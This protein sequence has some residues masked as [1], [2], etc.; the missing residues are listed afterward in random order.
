MELRNSLMALYKHLG[1]LAPAADKLDNK[2]FADI[3]AGAR[4]RIEQLAEHP[5]ADKV[6]EH[7]KADGPEPE[8]DKAAGPFGHKD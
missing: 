3:L 4:R 5:D 1:E 2:N 6:A 7:L 8:A